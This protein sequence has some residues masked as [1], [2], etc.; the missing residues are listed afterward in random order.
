MAQDLAYSYAGIIKSEKHDDGTLTVYGKA[1]DDSID[2]DNQICDADWLKTAMPEWMSSGGNI[3]EQHSNIAAGVATTLEEKA[4]GHYITALVVDPTSVKKVEKGVLKGFS[5]GIRSPRV[6]MDKNARGGRIVGGSV[7]E[8]SLVDRPANPNAKLMLAKAADTGELEAVNQVNIPTPAGIAKSVIKPL[9]NTEDKVEVMTNKSENPVEGIV[10]AVEAAA[11]EVEAVVEAVA[12]EV[13]T[14]AHDVEAVTPE[15]EHVVADVEQVAETVEAEKSVDAEIVKGD[16]DLYAAV[17]EALGALIKSETDEAVEGED[18]NKDIKQ[19]LKALKHLQ[20]WHAIEAEKG[21]VEPLPSDNAGDD[22]E[23]T[24]EDIF[25]AAKP[26][27]A[28]DTDSIIEKATSA[29]KAAVESELELVKSASVVAEERVIELEK[30]LAD[31]LSKAATGGPKRAAID[32]A[33]VK[34]NVDELIAKANTLEAKAKNTTD[35]TLARGYR[36][37]AADLRKKARKSQKG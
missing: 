30:Q 34:A 17:L 37:L 12:H 28:V 21:E 19:L 24:A 5:I 7:I 16:A 33:A 25:L 36:D 23:E 3:R 14:I 15:V 20:K 22:M 18:E 4:D 2:L 29:A 32:P 11:T 35:K 26:E 6:V 10:E 9:G 27:L 1:T 8:V 31:A 13:E